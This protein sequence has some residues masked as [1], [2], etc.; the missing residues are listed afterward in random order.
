MAGKASAVLRASTGED[1][2][3]ISF[4]VDPEMYTKL[5]ITKPRRGEEHSTYDTEKMYT[6]QLDRDIKKMVSKRGSYAQ[7]EKKF[8]DIRMIDSEY[9]AFADTKPFGNDGNFVELQRK[10]IP[11]SWTATCQPYGEIAHKRYL[12]YLANL[13]KGP[14]EEE[15]KDKQQRVMD[16]E[17]W[18][19]V[20]TG[21]TEPTKKELAAAAREA[22]REELRSQGLTDE[23]QDETPVLSLAEER[24]MHIN[25]HAFEKLRS[26]P[27]R[28]EFQG[29]MSKW[30][31]GIYYPYK[32]E[33]GFP[34]VNGHFRDTL[35]GNTL[36]EGADMNRK[37]S[38]VVLKKCKLNESAYTAYLG[39]TNYTKAKDYLDARKDKLERKAIREEKAKAQAEKS[40][41]RVGLQG[42]TI[43]N[44]LW[45]A[46]L[47][48]AKDELAFTAHIEK[49]D[50]HVIHE[51]KTHGLQPKVKKAADS[52]S[53]ESDDPDP[54]DP[55]G[56]EQVVTNAQ[57]HEEDYNKK[58]RQWLKPLFKGRSASVLPEGGE[59]A[60]QAGE[61]VIAPMIRALSESAV[62]VRDSLIAVLL[63]AVLC[64]V[65]VRWLFEFS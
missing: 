19:K 1:D 63:C 45:Q 55:D 54:D 33:K 43:S 20:I 48:H 58:R 2:Q 47:L 35:I 22:R 60:E 23:E 52:D 32:H 64:C 29:S 5:A 51:H 57:I 12:E 36:H 15:I 16:Q 61:G 17:L 41:R 7:R 59:V 11:I 44:D 18:T 8:M 10:T 62:A 46:R 26:L 42:M 49:A 14:T 13:P 4:S 37:Y 38:S 65:V 30:H 24:Q 40:R 28:R 9:A 53:S 25:H 56:D 21:R 3:S 6:Y 39:R 31:R 27:T 50:G 34:V